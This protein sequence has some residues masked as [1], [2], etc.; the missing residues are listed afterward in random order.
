MQR[1]E[2]FT[3]QCRVMRADS[4]ARG[5]ACVCFLVLF[6]SECPCVYVSACMRA[7]VRARFSPSISTV[8][9]K[10]ISALHM[11][12]NVYLQHSPITTNGRLIGV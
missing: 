4:S 6:L 11:F 8:F 9:S 10:S 12:L 3:V 7:C 5:Y 2:L 1:I